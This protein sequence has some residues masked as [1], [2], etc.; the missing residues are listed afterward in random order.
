MSFKQKYDA[1]MSRHLEKTNKV[2]AVAKKVAVTSA[3]AMGSLAA[4]LG[5]LIALGAIVGGTTERYHA[6]K[7]KDMLRP[8]DRKAELIEKN[9][10]DHMLFLDMDGDKN[11]AEAIIYYQMNCPTTIE[12]VRRAKVGDVKKVS[13]WKG[14]LF[15]KCWEE[16]FEWID[17]KTRQ[18]ED[19]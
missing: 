19:V 6:S 11:T 7:R 3:Y 13:E 10:K 1:F 16:H 4:V 17:V 8:D 14:S 15:D 5:G 18:R 12:A 9:E 2:A